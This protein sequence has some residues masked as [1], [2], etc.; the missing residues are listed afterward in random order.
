MNTAANEKGMNWFLCGF[1][2]AE[3][4]QNLRFS[5]F[6]HDTAQILDYQD[7]VKIEVSTADSLVCFNNIE[8]T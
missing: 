3:Q 6:A 5:E 2:M 7:E 4:N 8:E 1:E